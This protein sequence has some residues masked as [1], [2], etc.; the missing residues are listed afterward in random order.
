MARKGYIFTDKRES[1]RGVFSAFLGVLSMVSLIWA[2]YDTFL[3]RGVAPTRYGV[4][5]VLCLIFSI[6]GLITGIMAK[7]EQDRFYLFAWVGIGLNLLTI[8]GI[9]FILYAGAYGL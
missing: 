4:V 2:V 5:A 6:I 9:S 8:M 7:M 1:R 3:N